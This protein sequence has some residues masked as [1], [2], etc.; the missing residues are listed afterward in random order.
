MGI[1]RCL[2][3]NDWIYGW[4]KNNKIPGS[5]CFLNSTILTFEQLMKNG[6]AWMNWFITKYRPLF[7]RCK[8]SNKISTLTLF[9]W[10]SL[11]LSAIFILKLYPPIS[12]T[13]QCA[14]L[15]SL[16]F[17]CEV[18]TLIAHEFHWI[19]WDFGSSF[20]EFHLNICRWYSHVM[21]KFPVHSTSYIQLWPPLKLIYFRIAFI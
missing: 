18:K 6:F 19:E 3:E 10:L 16:V 12:A 5:Q 7:S 20:Y 2:N 14:V 13:I 4:K 15:H 17:K 9:T 11:H 8:I 21:L 1:F